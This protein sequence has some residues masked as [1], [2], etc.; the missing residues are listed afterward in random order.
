LCLNVVDR[1]L[2][3]DG[4]H[5]TFGTGDGKAFV[6]LV[7]AVLFSFVVLFDYGEA[8]PLDALIGCETALAI[9]A[10][11]TALDR[12]AVL[13]ETAVGDLC[14]FVV[15]VRTLHSFTILG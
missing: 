5:W 11:A 6:E 1:L 9:A 13:C 12:L 3:F 8:D 14:I 7:V 4:G 15:A 10:A 2:E